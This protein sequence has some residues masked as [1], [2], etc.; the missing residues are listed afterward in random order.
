MKTGIKY[1]IHT[2]FYSTVF[3]VAVVIPQ[4]IAQALN[5]PITH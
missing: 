1:T 4:A 3:L 2:M 5:A